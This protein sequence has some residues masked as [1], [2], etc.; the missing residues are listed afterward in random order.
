MGS[1]FVER[2][3]QKDEKRQVIRSPALTLACLTPSGRPSVCNGGNFRTC[4]AKCRFEQS[5][6]ASAAERH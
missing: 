2:E 5:I 4:L 1:S 3:A 6:W